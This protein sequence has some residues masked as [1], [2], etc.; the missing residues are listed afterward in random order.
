M[1]TRTRRSAATEAVEEEEEQDGVGRL[2]FKQPLVGRPGKPITVT[3]LFS[4]LKA[5]SDEL[6]GLEQEEVDRESLAPVAKELAHQSLLQHKDAGV[7]AWT[8]CCIVDIFSLCAPDA[9]YTAPQLKDIFSLIVG[10]IMPLLAD[11][12]NPYNGQHLYV[13]KSL[14]DI[15]SIVLITDLPS[16]GS[17]IATLFSNCF[18][19]LSGPS[20]AESGEELSMNVEHHMTQ[21]MS[22]VIEESSTVS[23]DVVDTILAQFLLADPAILSSRSK[24]K[25][26]VPADPKQTTLLRKEAP[27]AYNMAKS[28]CN[29][30]PDKMARLIG[31][32]FSS[33]IV[34]FTSG[35]SLS[36]DGDDLDEDEGRGPS[37]DELNDTLKAHRLLRELW[38]CAP[39]VLRDIIPHLQQ[40]LGTENVQLRQLATE[41]FG[42]MISGIGAAGPP[43]FPDLNPAAYPSHS[44]EPSSSTRSYNFLT[45]PTSQNSFPSQYPGPYHA[46][47]LRKQ[48]KTAAVRASWVTGVGRIL[49]TSAGGVGLDP[50]EEERLLNSF[51]QCLIDS[52]ERVRLAAVRAVAHFEFTDIISK[53]GSNGAMSEPGSILSNLADRVKDKRSVIHAESMTLLAKLWGVAA[54]A[55]GEGNERITRLLG[56]IP[57]K[58]LEAMYVND[59]EINLQ[60]DLALYDALL[61]LSYPPLKPKAVVNGGSQIVKDSQATGDQGYTEAELDKIRVERQLILVKGLEE[62]AKKVFFAKQGNQ[63]GIVQYM[64]AFLQLCEDYNGGV[65]AGKETKT[66]LDGLINYYSK[67][68]P[69]STVAAAD[70]WKFA[71]THDRRSYQLIRFCMAPDSDYRKVQKSIKELRKRIEDGPSSSTFLATLNPLLYRVSLLCYNKSHVPA[72]IDFSRSDE[73]GLGATAH[74]ILKEMSTKHPKVFSTHVKDLCK[75]LEQE[76]PTEGHPNPPGAVEDLKACSSFATKFP[77]DLPLNTKDGRKLVQAFTN[78][79][80]YGTPP[81]AA[82]HAITILMS[83]DNKKELRA[84]EL[85][86]KSINGFDYGADYF[87][88]RLATLSQLALLAPQECEDDAEALIDIAVNGVLMKP[89]AMPEEAEQEWMDV[90]DDDMAARIWALKLLVNRLRSNTIEEGSEENAKLV[91]KVLSKTVKEGVQAAKTPTPPAHRNLQRLLAA[92]HLIKLSMIRHYDKLLTPTVF[93]ELALV[94]QDPCSQVRKRFVTKLMKYLGQNKLPS[95]FYTILFLLA[96]EPE[97]EL[98]ENV[99]TWM[100]A[101]RAVFAAQKEATLETIFARLLSLLAHHP[102]FAKDHETLIL[103]TKYILFYLKCVATP[104][105]LS[106]IFHVA[107]RVKGVADGVNPSEQA[108]ENLYILS[109]LAQALIRSWEEQ[110]GWSMQSWPAKLKLPA[111][112]FK[113]LPTHEQAQQIADKVWLDEDIVEEL[114]VLVRQAMKNKKRKAVEGAEKPRKKAKSGAGVKKERTKSERAIKTPRKKRRTSGEDGGEDEGE[115]AAPSSGPRRKSDRRSTAKSYVELDTD[116]EEEDAQAGAE[117]SSDSEKATPEPEDVEMEDEEEE[118]MESEPEPEPKPAPPKKSARG[119]PAKKANGVKTPPKEKA[120]VAESPKASLPTRGAKS[121]AKVNGDLSSSP[122]TNGTVRRSGRSRG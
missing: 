87:L 51:A 26:N 35:A 16:S 115:D 73:K 95:R 55:I 94:A 109:E 48:D 13:L 69:D 57:S 114:D 93:N 41:T 24:G 7:R 14:A 23:P 101:R 62:K 30:N 63:A 80:L 28:I 34:N 58:I 67:T 82:K 65:K 90:P 18:D 10:K 59:A 71:E 25:K 111:G 118:Q 97:L 42:D 8:A 45:T 20:K 46:F 75:A 89:H 105:N 27:P 37:E 2:R 4:R 76:A 102:D 12:S 107:Q 64:E 29:A 21:M 5:L 79:A 78:F 38:R 98:Q 84:K 81:K 103:S 70:L 3:E 86:S 120:K 22:V 74:E 19:V 100:R 91:Y 49:M 85:L 99:L 56:P 72:V 52:E 113:A 92:N 15:K 60:V 9:P 110:N 43:P 116:E 119:R 117:E 83:S 47:L 36:K 31:S 112:I 6:R 11:P 108:D 121:K 66:K 32:Y 104:D 122:A 39:G 77:K 17:L 1:A 61:P 96:Y 68:L 53:I 106:L 33:V 54:G 44:L 40:E 50:E 88:T